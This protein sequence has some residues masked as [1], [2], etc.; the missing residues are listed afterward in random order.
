MARIDDLYRDPNAGAYEREEL[1]IGP[2]LDYVGE[3]LRHAVEY[4]HQAYQAIRNVDPGGLSS[5]D[6][7]A[8]LSRTYGSFRSSLTAFLALYNMLGLLTEPKKVDALLD[9]E[10]DALD[11]WLDRI[12][13]EGSVTG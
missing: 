11:E 2:P 12:V 10:A 4:A 9:L 13:Q 8:L 3:K 6:R 5:S 7:Q 1:R